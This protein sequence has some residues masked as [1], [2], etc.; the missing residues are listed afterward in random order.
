V[1][2]LSRL[3][4]IG[5]TVSVLGLVFLWMRSRVPDQRL[6]GGFTTYAR[7][8][9]GSHL[10]IGSPVIIAGVR[11]GEVTDLRIEGRFARV[12][13][14]LQKDIQIPVDAFVTRRADSLFGDSYIEL[15]FSG[16]EEGAA[17]VRMLASGEPIMHVIEGASTDAVLRGVERTMPTLED[18]QRDRAHR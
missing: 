10:A 4:T 6:G 17:P 16:Q 3:V 5:I 11:I 14:N 13:M 18:A 1:R 15:I 8:R 2:W 9:D 12:D 7:F